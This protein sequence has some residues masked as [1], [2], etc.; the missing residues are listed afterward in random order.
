MA[1]KPNDEKFEVTELDDGSLDDVAGG[2]ADSN[3]N[4][5]TSC[6]NSGNCV[7]QCGGPCEPAQIQ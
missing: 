3:N 7:A 6:E 1:K 4:C 2:F 5:G